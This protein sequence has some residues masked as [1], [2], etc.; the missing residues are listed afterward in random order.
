MWWKEQN[1]F[2]R[3]VETGNSVKGS[4]SKTVPMCFTKKD[5]LKVVCPLISGNFY[6]D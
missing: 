2:V 3:K 5:D 1:V 4:V 6:L